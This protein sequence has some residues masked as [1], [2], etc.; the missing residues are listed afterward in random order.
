MVLGILD[1]VV[2]GLGCRGRCLV[3][4]SLF[5]DINTG[6]NNVGNVIGSNGRRKEYDVTC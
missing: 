1:Q 2:L 6:L 3:S 4:F 5:E